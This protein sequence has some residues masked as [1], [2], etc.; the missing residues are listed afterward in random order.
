MSSTRSTG[1]LTWGAFVLMLGL[2]A[3]AGCASSIEKEPQ[4]DKAEGAE[5]TKVSADR[6]Y[7]GRVDATD[8][9]VGVAVREDQNELI[10]YVSDGLP[11]GPEE[12]LTIDAWFQ[13]TIQDNLADLTQ[14]GERLQALINPE[15]VVGIYALP[16]GDTHLFVAEQVPVDGD[17]GVYWGPEPEEGG[18]Q[19]RAGKIVLASGEE[20][21]TSYPQFSKSR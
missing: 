20:R 8:A 16:D 13:G 4:E 7:A 1:R 19:A 3:L 21:G 17:A 14:N 2:S 15:S 18:L 10:A 9:F 6:M 11:E 5:V 12:S